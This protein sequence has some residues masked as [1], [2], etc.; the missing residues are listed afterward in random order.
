MGSGA[1]VDG[2]EVLPVVEDMG[3]DL[4]GCFHGG[5]AEDYHAV[6]KGVGV[7]TVKEGNLV[8][9]GVAD[10][11]DDNTKAIYLQMLSG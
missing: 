11:R 10:T 7:C 8:G 5:C 1:F 2:G 4:F 3:A 6:G 9:I